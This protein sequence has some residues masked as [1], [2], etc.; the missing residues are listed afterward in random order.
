[1]ILL[2]EGCN[3]VLP[4]DGTCKFNNLEFW[5]DT[6][7]IELLSLSAWIALRGHGLQQYVWKGSYETLY[8]IQPKAAFLTRPTV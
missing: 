1:M 3:T 4:I 8:Y 6:S 7:S 5:I 2:L